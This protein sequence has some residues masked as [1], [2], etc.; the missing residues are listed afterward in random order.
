MHDDDHVELN[1]L[2]Q[3]CSSSTGG[4]ICTLS[5]TGDDDAGG[6]NK[7]WARPQDRSSVG[8][9]TTTQGKTNAECSQ[10]CIKTSWCTGYLY[11][12]TNDHA[13]KDYPAFCNKACTL[14]ER[15][16]VTT[17]G[18]D[19]VY[20]YTCQGTCGSLNIHCG[21][22]FIAKPASTK[23]NLCKHDGDECCTAK[24]CGTPGAGVLNVA[25][26]LVQ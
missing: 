19:H 15:L 11:K 14:L 4:N 21:T 8:R 23:C 5:H 1:V 7:R 20:S 10:L 3:C 24:T 13:C 17:T 2:C 6:D 9:S 25:L 22:G 26:Q 16:K 18:V 12:H